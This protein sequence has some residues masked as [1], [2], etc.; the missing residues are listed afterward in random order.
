MLK[1]FWEVCEV[2]VEIERVT[3][4]VVVEVLGSGVRHSLD[5]IVQHVSKSLCQLY[6]V[7]YTDKIRH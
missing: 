5:N 7:N 6:V 3:Y 1:S 4:P 2:I